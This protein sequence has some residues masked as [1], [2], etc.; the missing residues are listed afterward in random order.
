MNQTVLR[1]RVRYHHRI[2]TRTR[3]RLYAAVYL[4]AAIVVAIRAMDGVPG[5]FGTPAFAC[6]LFAGSLV[7]YRWGHQ[8]TWTSD[9]RYHRKVSRSFLLALRIDPRIPAAFTARLL[10]EAPW[11]WRQLD[12]AIREFD[13]RSVTEGEADA[14]A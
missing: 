7:M 4:V 10:A 5:L 11:N 12:N 9:K 3:V 1:E 2:H 13:E 6:F 14:K 8:A